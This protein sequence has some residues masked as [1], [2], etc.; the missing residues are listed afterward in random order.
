MAMTNRFA[1]FVKTASDLDNRLKRDLSPQVKL[2]RIMELIE[3]AESVNLKLGSPAKSYLIRSEELRAEA[4]EAMWA[5]YY[6]VLKY[7]RSTEDESWNNRQ[8]NNATGTWESDN[9]AFWGDGFEDYVGAELHGSNSVTKV[10]RY[11]D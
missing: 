8:F 11:D 6:N 4:I 1:H 9:V 3:K 10:V 5:I 2:S 7:V